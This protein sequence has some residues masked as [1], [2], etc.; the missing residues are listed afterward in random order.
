M[1]KKQKGGEH[2]VEAPKAAMGLTT[3]EAQARR[4]AGEGNVHALPPTRSVGDILR[5]NLLT[6]FNLL[7]LVLA[8]LVLSVGSWK[9]VL[10]LGVIVS[11]A[12]IG[13][14]QELRAKAAVDK[15]S[16][17][18]APHA[19]TLRDGDLVSLP[20]EEL[21]R[22]DV[23]SLS[24]G[25]QVGAD[26]AILE[27]QCL[28]DEALLTG[29][30][31]PVERGVGDTLL[32]GSFLVSGR[33]LAQVVHVGAENYAA[34]ITAGAKR[35]KPRQS[36][37]MDT[38]DRIIRAIGFLLVPVGLALFVKQCF[39]SGHPP[40]LAVV[41]T[42]AALVGMIPEGLVLLTSV[43]MAVSAIRLAG[44][45][46]LAQELYCVENL[47]RVDVL[48]L[49]KT[50]TLTTGELTVAGLLPAP[51]FELE[52]VKNALAALLAATGDQNPTARALADYAGP[53]PDW[54]VKKA[55]PFRS[56]RKWSGGSFEH[57]ET[58]CLGAAEFL[59]PQG[60]GELEKAAAG[61]AAHGLRVVVLAVGKDELGDGLPGGLVPAALIF[62]SDT[63]RPSAAETL[64]YFRA[65]GVSLKLLSGDD[66]RTVSA[67]AK[68]AG[69]D[70]ETWVDA[71]T[72]EGEDATRA[73]AKDHAIFGRVTPEQKLWLIQA[74]RAQGH[75]V[76]MVGDGVNDVLALRESDCAVA[77]A[78]GSQAARNVSQVVL[79]DSDFSVMPAIV[80]EGR[81]AI[82]NLQRSAA[83]FLTKTGF[84]VLTALCFLFLSV[85]YPFQPIQ[86]TLISVLTIGIPSFLLA[87]EPN[88][89]RVRG[90][91]GRN[92]LENALPGALSMA[93]VVL[94]CVALS[95][96]FPM[97]RSQF[98]TLCVLLVGFA[99]LINLTFVAR[100][101]NVRRGLLVTAMA[102]LFCLEAWFLR[103][104]FSLT[105]PLP[106]RL[107]LVAALLMAFTV[108]VQ[109]LLRRL[110]E[111]RTRKSEA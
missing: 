59:F 46:A 94:L 22:F 35:F 99:G 51:G 88:F 32:S 28:M 109:L 89:D 31:E 61:G 2:S 3:A 106:P 27:G 36:E 71:A 37:I 57:G 29:E 85:L 40:Q 110:M 104:L 34:R 18:A 84:S 48:C 75:T 68:Q 58:W 44:R 55:A 9:N 26:C 15:L 66:P 78:S 17:I 6:P 73:A 87:L 101:L 81:R 83:L 60:L 82:N 79:M 102:A 20:L 97:E 91:F 76:A 1:S 52:R 11:N 108:L 39:F 4:A 54:R 90:H 105:L 56:D 95:I 23:I 41:S 63:L 13:I 96:P 65:Q 50:G 98:S 47:A 16:L 14:V 33:C 72:L 53:V 12:V 74:W 10:F 77:M 67:L 111:Q 30:S 8:T 7:N 80:A 62:L 64:R 5:S 107:W 92:V 69:F 45:G 93:A 43:V 100:P 21:V 49:D 103:G 19:N 24:A 70:D 42:V 38:V 25:D 86:L